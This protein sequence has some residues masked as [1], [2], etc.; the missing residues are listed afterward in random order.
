MKLRYKYRFYPTEPQQQILAR[1]FGSCR[2]VYNW[3]LRFRTDSYKEGTTIN[4]NQ[5]S[6]ELTKLKK[7]EDHLWLNEVSSVPTQQTLRRLQTAFR[8]F[9]DKRSMYPRFKSRRSK[10]S[11][12]YTRSAF[13]WDPEN[14]QL[15]IAQ[16]GKL[17]IRWSRDFTSSPSTVTITKD[18]A[19][20]YFVTLVLDEEK[21]PLPKTGK[22]VGVDLGINRLVTL[23]NGW[24]LANPK[25]LRK[26]LKRLARA[27]KDLARKEKGSNR[28]E[29]Q[30]LKVAKL[31][32]K[33]A[34]SRA[35]YLHKATT[36]LVQLYDVICMEDLNVRGM[37]RNHSLALSISDAAFGE[38]RRQVKY[39]TKWYGK[40]IRFVDRFFPS[41]KR[42]SGCG[43]VVERLPL[44][45]RRWTCPECGTEHDRDENA[46]KNIEMAAGQAVTARG[47]RVSRAVAKATNRSALGSANQS[48]VSSAS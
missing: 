44:N 9:F 12:E 46:A 18:R 43:F 25:H 6:A 4:Y 42:C 47:G 41:S 3:A 21:E 29:K 48:G 31:Y 5:S 24:R 38:F 23:S 16:L 1:V 15:K 45:V 34:D 30:R 14:K 40:E 37:V 32:T 36:T 22:S 7:Q 10:Q 35:D 20:R 19:G 26:H 17:K 27:Q 11:A 2:Y 39:K 28:W 13:K 8:N 33:I